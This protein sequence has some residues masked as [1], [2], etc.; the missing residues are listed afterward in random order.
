MFFLWCNGFLWGILSRLTQKKGKQMHEAAKGYK[1]CRRAKNIRM[2]NKV[3]APS[4]KRHEKYQKIDM[5]EYGTE[6]NNVIAV[7]RLGRQH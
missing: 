7:V 4:I 2:Y 6:L 5:A 1:R 3:T